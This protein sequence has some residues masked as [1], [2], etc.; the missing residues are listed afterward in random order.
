MEIAP[1][2]EFTYFRKDF[3]VFLSFFMWSVAADCFSSSFMI[4]YILLVSEDDI[5]FAHT[6]L[7]RGNVNRAYIAYTASKMTYIVS[8]GALNST[9]SILCSKE[10]RLVWDWE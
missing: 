6:W 9:P 10:T 1:P 7:G 4:H 2:Y 8:S 3:T 5:M